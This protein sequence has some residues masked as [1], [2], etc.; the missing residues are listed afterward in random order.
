MSDEIKLGRVGHY[1]FQQ[2]C[3]TASISK[4][5]DEAFDPATGA[6]RG[7]FVN[8]AGFSHD[9]DPF[10]RRMVPVGPV[11]GDNGEWHFNKDC[12]WAK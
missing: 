6:S 12:P 2:T 5:L 4:V 3:Q 11:E 9:G 8:V 1:S 10:S 7:I